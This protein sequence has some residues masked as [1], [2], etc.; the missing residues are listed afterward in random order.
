MCLL[1][2]TTHD[3]RFLTQ[4]SLEFMS[5]SLVVLLLEPELYVKT[6]DQGGAKIASSVTSIDYQ[7]TSIVLPPELFEGCSTG[8]LIGVAEKPI[9]CTY[10]LLSSCCKNLQGF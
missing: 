2:N 8:K 1:L 4:P 7:G 10:I 5:L 3:C 9:K 6:I